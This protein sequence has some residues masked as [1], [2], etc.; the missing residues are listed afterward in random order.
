MRILHI[1]LYSFTARSH[2]PSEIS[3]RAGEEVWVVTKAGDGWTLVCRGDGE[4]GVVPTDYLGKQVK[5]KK[6]SPKTADAKHVDGTEGE[7]REKNEKREKKEKR[8]EVSGKTK[9]KD[10]K[11]ELRSKDSSKHDIPHASLDGSDSE[12]DDRKVDKQPLS[13]NAGSE[14]EDMDSKTSPPLLKH[15]DMDSGRPTTKPHSDS[16]KGSDIHSETDGI[17]HTPPLEAIKVDKQP[18]S[19][20]A[21]SE[22]EDMDSKTSPPLLKHIDMDSGRPT[23]KPHSDSLKGSDIHSETDG[24]DHTP[25]LEA[26][27]PSSTQLIDSEHIIDSDPHMDDPAPE[28]SPL[29]SRFKRRNDEIL[30]ESGMMKYCTSGKAHEAEDNIKVIIRCRPINEMEKKQGSQ[31]VV[32]IKEDGELVVHR[33]TKDGKKLSKEFTFDAVYGPTSLQK[34]IFTFSIR[35]L[36]DAAL[37]GYNATIFAYGQTG[38]GKSFTM[39]GNEKDEDLRGVIPRTFQHIFDYKSVAD[40][41]EEYLFRASYIELYGDNIYDLLI[42]RGKRE[43]KQSLKLREHPEKGVYIENVTLTPIRSEEEVPELLEIGGSNRTVASTQMNDVSSRSHSIFQLHLEVS[44]KYDD[45]SEHIRVGKLNLVDL[46]GSE[47][48]KKTK[49]TGQRQK[50]GIEINKSLSTLCRVIRN[51]NEG[52]THIPYRESNL[53]RLLQDSI[54]GNS[55]TVMIA[56][57][58]PASFNIDETIETL[59]YAKRAKNIK[60]TPKI[61]EDPKDAM[62]RQMRLQIEKLQEELKSAHSTAGAADAASKIAQIA[63]DTGNASA[64]RAAE[65]AAQEVIYIQ[66]GESEEEKKKRLEELAQKEQTIAEEKKA[67]EELAIELA[68]KEKEKEESVKQ[69][70]IMESK[71]TEI[72]KRGQEIFTEARKKEAEARKLENELRDKELAARKLKGKIKE[73]EEE[74]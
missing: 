74:A 10:S 25:P 57:I 64:F 18:L 27:S 60:N 34:D 38:S 36:V 15:I 51:L 58:S 66:V 70:R 26:M 40:E 3:V 41:S 11:K 30:H 33:K 20:N 45:G 14:G 43:E 19:P 61:N 50:E 46:A 28:I 42:K 4:M 24:I 29:K 7:K 6:K 12:K 2:K 73:K 67:K 16:L 63:T 8:E 37:D 44:K 13:P 69:L 68:E 21:G 9:H 52:L 71:M 22:G 5:K 39:M 65:K 59:R 62:L 31:T 17:D 32:A 1:M 53:T 35:S 55:K 23:T 54:G 49:A 48:L 56:N 47:T 72:K